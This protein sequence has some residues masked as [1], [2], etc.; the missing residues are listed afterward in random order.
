MKPKF[1]A[2]GAALPH[3]RDHARRQLLRAARLSESASESAGRR[4]GHDGPQGRATMSFRS[5]DLVLS[6]RRRACWW[7]PTARKRIAEAAAK[8]G[9]LEPGRLVKDRSALDYI[10]VFVGK[11]SMVGVPLV[12]ASAAE[13]LPDASP[14]CP[15]LRRRHRA[16][17]RS[18][19]GIRR[20]RRRADAAGPQGR[21]PQAFRR[22]A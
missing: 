5:D 2:E 8:F 18:D 7:W 14:A 1:P 12:A 4:A 16:D 3:G 10:R 13:R 22:H 20:S 9:K 15:P 6:R 11:A 21:G 17:A 19:A